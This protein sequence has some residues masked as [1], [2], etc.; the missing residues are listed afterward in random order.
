VR[1]YKKCHFLPILWFAIASTALAAEGAPA[2]AP[3]PAPTNTS[4]PSNNNSPNRNFYQVLDD[5]LGDF[6]Y[7]LKNGSVQGLKELAIRNVAVS[8]NV[9]PSFKSHLELLVTEKIIKTTRNR[10]LQCLE[11]RAKKTMLNGD[12]VVITSPET[13]GSELARIAKQNGI[14]HFMDIAFSY[15]A[16]GMVLSLYVT[17]A[18]TDAVIW[19][20]TYNSETSR[21]AA[22]RQGI[23]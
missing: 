5:V 4:S 15:Q 23:D 8:E 16:T 14:S 1:P 21:A 13:N 3:A 20:R 19:T 10:V 6:E 11:C 22:A 7:D 18:D 17:D 9:P 12:Q 2:S